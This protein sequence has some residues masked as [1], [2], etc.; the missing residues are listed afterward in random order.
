[1]EILGVSGSLL[2][3]NQQPDKK[4]ALTNDMYRAAR[5]ALERAQA[6]KSIRAVLFGA[7]GNA[8]TAGNDL[9]DFANVSSGKSGESQA[10]PFIQALGQFE[11]PIV[12]AV[13]GIAVGVGTTMLLHCDLVYVAD[14]AKLTAPFVN[15]ALVPEAA[16]SLLMPARIGYVKAF[17]AFALGESISGPEAVTLGLANKALPLEEVL[18]AARAAAQTLAKKPAGSLVA[19]KKLMRDGEIILARMKQESAIFA[20]R[21]RSDEAREAFS[22]FAERRQPDFSKFAA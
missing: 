17:A 4:N 22:A 11:K 13:P 9:G 5:E 20:E 16:S 10:G 14:T 21:L 18:P 12:A 15:L 8:F 3:G 6:D 7:E 2:R 1:M 19:T